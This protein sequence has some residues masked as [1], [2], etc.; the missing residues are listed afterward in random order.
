MNIT[1]KDADLIF[2]GDLGQ[3]LDYFYSVQKYVCIRYSEALEYCKVHNLS[4]DD[5]KTWYREENVC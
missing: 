4:E 3:Q 5:V 1:Q 2:A